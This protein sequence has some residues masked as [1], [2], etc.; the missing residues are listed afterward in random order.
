MELLEEQGFFLLNGNVIDY[1][2]ANEIAWPDIR[3]FKVADK[4]QSD[5][6]PLEVTLATRENYSQEHHTTKW[7][8]TL[9]AKNK[10]LYQRRL[11]AMPIQG[12]EW[13]VLADAMSEATPRHLWRERQPDKSWWDEECY[14]ARK[15]KALRN[16]RRDENF[17]TFYEVRKRYKRLIRDRKREAQQKIIDELS[18]IKNMRDAWKFIN[19]HSTQKKSHNLPSDEELCNH[20]TAILQAGPEK[21]VYSNETRNAT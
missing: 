21:M 15:E 1:G 20:F 5:H 6:F 18:R 3:E 16:A 10:D 19:K 8:Q 4:D 17:H 7:I 9:S 13:K 12:D 2:A 11:K 14:D